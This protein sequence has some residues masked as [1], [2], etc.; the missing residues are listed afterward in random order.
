MM[1]KLIIFLIVL[2][3]FPLSGRAAGQVKVAVAS[4]A[5]S[6]SG[7]GTADFTISGF[8]TPKACIILLSF[9][10]TDDTAI[11]VQNRASIGFSDFTNHRSITHQAEDASARVDSDARKSATKAYVILDIAGVVD[12]D[13]TASTITDGVQLTN[14]TNTSAS[15]VFATVIMFNGSDLQVS[16]D[17]VTI[18]STVGLTTVTTTGI[19]QDLVFFIGTDIAGEDSSSTAINNSFGVVDISNDQATIVNRSMGWCSDHNNNVGSPF[20]VIRN[21]RALTMI[22]EAGVLDWGIELTSA[23]TTSYTVTTRDVTPGNGMEVYALALDLD[24]RGSKIGSVDSPTSG[25]TWTPSVSLGFTPQHVGLGVTQAQVE[26]TIEDD[27]DA[28]SM[29]ISSNTGTGEETFH[30]WYSDDG[31]ATTDTA[32]NFR[33]R[34]IDFRNDDTSVIVQDHSHS[35]F[36][37]GGWTYTINTENETIARKWFYWAIE[38]ASAP[39][40]TNPRAIIIGELMEWKG[41]KW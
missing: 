24:D 1:K 18:N 7:T 25:A 32:N 19:P 41:V 17:S 39:P 40:A 11:S 27:A 2:L 37:S 21:D 35:S 6:S 5:I 16:L 36:D 8:G 9:D 13:G 15:A 31:G 4:G 22:T 3:F 20:S 12:I 14:T 34:V 33:S 28:G 26:G 23:T 10:T 38:V 30:G 29:G